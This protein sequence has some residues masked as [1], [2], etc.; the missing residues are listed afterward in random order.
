MAHLP[1]PPQPQKNNGKS[2][3]F[4]PEGSYY[5]CFQDV[6]PLPYTAWLRMSAI[7]E[8]ISANCYVFVLWPAR[9]LG[10]TWISGG[11]PGVSVDRISLNTS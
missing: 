9:T 10:W 11:L 1:L 3:N 2:S 4:F 8:L 7:T 6:L 5:N